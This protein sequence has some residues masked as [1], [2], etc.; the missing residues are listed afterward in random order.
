MPT[1]TYIALA[2][3]TLSGTASSITFSSIPATYRDLV[4]VFNGSMS[5]NNIRLILRFNGSSSNY[6]A[7]RM[8]GQ[9]NVSDTQTQ[10]DM[11]YADGRVVGIANIMDYS[12]TDKHKTALVRF[13]D[14][15][16]SNGETYTQAWAGRWASTNAINQV[17]VTVA[18]GNI[19]SGSTLA[20]Y[21]IVS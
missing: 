5:A 13:G 3:T 17:A 10:I 20:L 16:A 2:N 7:V 8:F 15:G 18:S 9:G 14:L 1:A 21:G 4:L 19:A 12:A 11:G 6:T